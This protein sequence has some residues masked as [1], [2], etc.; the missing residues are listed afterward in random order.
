MMASAHTRAISEI[1]STPHCVLMMSH[2]AV[3]PWVLRSQEDTT[4]EIILCFDFLFVSHPLLAS[5]YS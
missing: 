2:E 3:L 4:S 1:T 5:I